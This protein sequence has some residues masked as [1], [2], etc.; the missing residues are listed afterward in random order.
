[1]T[2]APHRLYVLIYLCGLFTVIFFIRYIF[3][4]IAAAHFGANSRYLY[5]TEKSKVPSRAQH[6]EAETRRRFGAEKTV[7][8][9][10]VV[11]AFSERPCASN[12][13][14]SRSGFIIILVEL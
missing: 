8:M 7:C 10:S 4:A 9:T 13:V 14:R 11:A 12:W 5:T 3:A 1:M 2:L 6:M